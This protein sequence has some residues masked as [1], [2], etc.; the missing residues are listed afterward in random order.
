MAFLG[1]SADGA[2]DEEREGPEEQSQDDYQIEDPEEY[3][4]GR[5]L[6]EICD[7]KEAVRSRRQEI[8]VMISD[9]DYPRVDRHMGAQLYRSAVEDFIT[10]IEPL[11][12]KEN[13][14]AGSEY[15]TEKQI[16]QVTAAPPQ[17]LRSSASASIFN[18]YQEI[19]EPA[20][21]QTKTFTG[22]KSI[23]E[24]S[25][26][27][28][29]EFTAV[30]KDVRS[31]QTAEEHGYTHKVIPW[32]ILVKAHRLGTLFLA[33]IGAEVDINDDKGG[34]SFDY[35]DIVDD[36]LGGSDE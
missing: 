30:V 4:K 10:A 24:A 29:F 16:G 26:P 13:E 12:V 6:R 15:W 17:E 3:L 20:T 36:R 9:P 8:D 7:A 33:E 1:A 32:Q 5:R 27:L 31:G 14:D 35:R 23:V 34:A 11:L 28:R 19:V 2:L 18:G 21:P 25:R 22:L